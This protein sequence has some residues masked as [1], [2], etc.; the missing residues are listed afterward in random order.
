MRRRH[1]RKRLLRHV[2]PKLQAVR[3]NVREPFLHKLGVLVR[4]VQHHAFRARFLHL[5]VDGAGHD[6]ARGEVGHGMIAFHERFAVLAP[7]NAALPAHGLADQ[8]RFGLRMIQAGGMKLDELHVR[9][10]GA[11]PIR[12]RHAVAAG[13]V[14]IG[15]V[16]IHLA[17][18]ARGQERDLRGKHFHHGPLLVQRVATQAT[19]RPGLAQLLR[20]DQVDDQGILEHGDVLVLRHRR[21]Q[22]PLDFA[23][24]NV[25]RVQHPPPGVA[26]FATEIVLAARVLLFG[27][28]HPQLDQLAHQRRPFTDDRAHHV[29]PAQPRPGIQRVAHVQ[30]QRIVLGHH[31]RDAALGIIGVALRAML[32]GNQ[33]HRPHPGHF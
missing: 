25:A 18:T 26:A 15:R 16:E 13:D 4:D 1:H 5:G 30:F 20:S 11:R 32:L 22:G 23:P 21:Q 7:Q 17:R 3:V 31:R 24:R 19:V 6:V 9:H 27:E 14:G 28:F 33:P 2:E 29:L 10:A 8:K 12:H